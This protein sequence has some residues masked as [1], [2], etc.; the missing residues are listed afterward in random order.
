LVT[1]FDWNTLF[2]A[3]MVAAIA[4]NTMLVTATPIIISSRVNPRRLKFPPRHG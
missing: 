3:T 1:P 2:I 4:T